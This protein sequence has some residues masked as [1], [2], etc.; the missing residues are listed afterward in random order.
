[1]EITDKD[2]RKVAFLLIIVFLAILV[3]FIVRPIIL[4][5][6]SGL[7][8]AYVCFPIYRWILCRVKSKTLAASIIT[9]LV[10]LAIFL[11]IWYLIPVLVEQV[12][13]FFQLIQTLDISSFLRNLF[14]NASSQFIAQT[15]TAIT[16]TF[17]NLSST[18][19]ASLVNFLIDLPTFALKLL[20][21]GFVFFYTL[22]DFD[23]L[24]EFVSGLSPL[25]KPQEQALVRQFRGITESIVYGQVLIGIIQGILVGIG[26]LIFGVDNALLLTVLASIFAIIPMIGPAIVYIPVALFMLVTG[27]TTSAIIFLLYCL[28]IVSTIDN[29]L[30]IILMSRK[31]D[32]SQAIILVGMIGG[33]FLFGILGLILGPLI[34]AYFIIF[35]KAYREKTLSSMF[36]HES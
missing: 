22:R 32:L 4:S 6:V 27:Q 13:K 30:R 33:L 34:V 26:L 1:M 29:F 9:I 10:I 17:N 5:V 15:A 16:T 7:I 3:F 35:L 25:N 21:A 14:P 11:P 36:A 28:L 20:L 12:F 8:L 23:S 18:I 19:T 31:T 24:K 2:A